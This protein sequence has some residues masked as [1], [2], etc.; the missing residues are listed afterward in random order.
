[1]LTVV[2]EGA[3]A[4]MHVLVLSAQTKNSVGGWDLCKSL[5]HKLYKC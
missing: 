3:T 5:S 4:S 1:M 2:H